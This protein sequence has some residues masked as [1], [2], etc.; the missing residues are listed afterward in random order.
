MGQRRKG[1]WS[2]ELTPRVALPEGVMGPGW[3]E[4]LVLDPESGE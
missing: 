3:A 2:G 1:E 4:A